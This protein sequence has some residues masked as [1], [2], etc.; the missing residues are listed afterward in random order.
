MGYTSVMISSFLLLQIALS[1]NW[2]FHRAQ[3]DRLIF[4]KWQGMFYD[5]WDVL[6]VLQTRHLS[7]KQISKKDPRLSHVHLLSDTKKRLNS[8][9]FA[10]C[11][12]KINLWTVQGAESQFT[13]PWDSL[14]LSM[15]M[16]EL[17]FTKFGKWEEQ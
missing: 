5:N 9:T 6:I 4:K 1:S 16:V 10:I 8:N 11:K 12:N 15:V 2:H 13:N 3:I 14:R 7:Y 17:S